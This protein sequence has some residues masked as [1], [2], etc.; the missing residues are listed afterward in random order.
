MLRS[1][2]IV[3]DMAQQISDA[4]D[5]AFEA[6]LEGE[7]SEEPQVTD[8]ILGAIGDRVRGYRSKGIV[9]KARTLR[10]GRGIA[11]EEK[12]HGADILGVLDIDIEGYKTKK[13]F[14]AQAKK[15]EASQPFGKAEWGRLREQCEVMLSRTAD[16]FVFVYS[17]E[18]GIRIFPANSVLGLS[19][20]NIF[21]LYDRSVASFFEVHIECF[22]GDP[23]LGSTDI[24]TLDALAEF[25]VERVLELSAR[26]ES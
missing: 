10:T 17:K 2:G 24:A 15:A 26:A 11:A 3:R 9:W 7:A 14:L 16:A 18:R 4:A 21:H 19:S 25:Q 22:V 8:R 6:Y 12:R 1:L 23:R 13:G 20:T 5:G